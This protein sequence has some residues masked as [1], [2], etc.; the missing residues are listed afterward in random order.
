[1]E[2]ITLTEPAATKLRQ[3]LESRGGAGDAL[4]VKVTSGGC[5]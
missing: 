4:R 2:L 1:M 3:Q 5:S